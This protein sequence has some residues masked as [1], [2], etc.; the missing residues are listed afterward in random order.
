MCDD[1][2]CVG[3]RGP[4]ELEGRPWLNSAHISPAPGAP[5]FGPW[6]TF[7][8]PAESP[9]KILVAPSECFLETLIL[10]PET[11]CLDRTLGCGRRLTPTLQTPASCPPWACLRASLGLT[12]VCQTR[13][14]GTQG[15]LR[16]A[17]H[18][19]LLFGADYLALKD[20][21]T[22]PVLDHP[23]NKDTNAAEFLGLPAQLMTY[24]EQGEW[25]CISQTGL[26]LVQSW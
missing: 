9:C 19:G 7:W 13:T 22:I 16:S 6:L 26:S 24:T 15:G 8:M 3:G 25:S 5:R 4:G 20:A 14:Q 10:K 11:C 2:A 23:I 1:P 21:P 17:T 18:R 12:S